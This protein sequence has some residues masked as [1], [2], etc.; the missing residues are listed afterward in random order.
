MKP[1]ASTWCRANDHIFSIVHVG[2]LGVARVERLSNQSNRRAHAHRLGGP[3]LTTESGG[4]N[5]TMRTTSLPA[6]AMP[7]AT[8]MKIFSFAIGYF[9]Q[10]G[11]CECIRL[12]GEST[13]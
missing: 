3:K 4:S 10:N 8:N 1:E 7:A 9:L 5:V 6:F 11:E 12:V 2:W 13:L